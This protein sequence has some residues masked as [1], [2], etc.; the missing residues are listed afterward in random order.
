MVTKRKKKVD[1]KKP[2]LTVYRLHE[3]IDTE[4]SG[5]S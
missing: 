1:I 5:S 4:N 3:R 2:Q